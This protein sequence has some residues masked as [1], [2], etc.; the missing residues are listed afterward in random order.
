M[1]NGKKAK[2]GKSRVRAVQSLP[3]SGCP[4]F[5]PAMAPVQTRRFSQRF[6]ATAAFS[7]QVTFTDLLDISCQAATATSAYRK[8]DAIRL[9][10]IRLWCTTATLGTNTEILFY[11]GGNTFGGSGP[12]KV[13]VGEA[14][15]TAKPAK[16]E[17]KWNDTM[18]TG[19]W[20]ST[21]SSGR[22]FFM[23]IPLGTTID[24][25]MN[26]TTADDNA[27]ATA[28]SAGVAAAT[29]GVNYIRPLASS[30]GNT[31]T[32]IGVNVI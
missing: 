20:Q 26:Y 19:Q 18:Q 17:F 7:G 22:A 12:G 5:P 9:K 6:K 31:L 27:N 30:T 13:I 2:S 28:V 3:G 8:W 16:V 4:N 15:G 11:P 1:P 24:L 25:E 23:T 21:S 32:P 10:R 29:V 14:M